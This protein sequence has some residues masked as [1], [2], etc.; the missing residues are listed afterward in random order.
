MKVAEVISKVNATKPNQ[1]NDDQMTGFI[2]TLEQVVQ[3]EVMLRPVAER[4][5][6]TWANNQDS[7]LLM[8]APYDSCY[9]FYVSAM[10]DYHNQEFESYNHNM[11][12]FNNLYDDY[13]KAYKRTEVSVSARVQNIW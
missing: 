7:E 2:D 9:L 1:Y 3:A 12:H 13:K 5:G 10:I 8:T 6:Y 4:V 11:A